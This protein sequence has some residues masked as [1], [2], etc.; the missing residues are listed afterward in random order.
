M[1]DSEEM[2][3]GCGDYSDD[4]DGPI[5]GMDDDDTPPDPDL[6][7]D[8]SDEDE[9]KI[10]SEDPFS[11][12]LY[13]VS[14]GSLYVCPNVVG[15]C[16]ED[17]KRAG[18]VRCH[19]NVVVVDGAET[20]TALSKS[21]SDGYNRAWKE[22]A[23]RVEPAQIIVVYARIRPE[24]S[25]TEKPAKQ[26]LGDELYPHWY[27]SIKVEGEPS[28]DALII[29]HIPKSA[30]NI[31][32]KMVQKTCPKSSLLDMESPVQNAR[33]INASINTSRELNVNDGSGFRKT[34]V[35][36]KTLVLGKVKEEKPDKSKLA[37]GKAPKSPVSAPVSPAASPPPS[38][39]KP[40]KPKPVK[41]AKTMF[42]DVAPKKPKE[43]PKPDVKKEPEVKKPDAKKPEVK[44]PEAK[45]PAAKEPA[46]KEP[47]AKE[48]ADGVR[49]KRKYIESADVY[50]LEPSTK[51]I[52][53]HIPDGVDAT[54]VDVVARYH[55]RA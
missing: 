41:N 37:N 27:I 30:Y 26:D 3:D 49:G 36:L 45:E 23:M 4:D 16:T 54:S 5:P 47:A 20:L 53:L 42:L 21:S 17:D 44:K 2:H 7:Q 33:A 34:D 28:D 46:A 11:G 39:K 35:S 1:S 38:P 55:V 31:I 9:H 25:R 12:D 43:S 6:V 13:I 40:P 18:Y 51:R 10:S 29:R 14:N 32:L 50:A 48:P 22:L 8:E 19:N 52:I 24:K 15:K